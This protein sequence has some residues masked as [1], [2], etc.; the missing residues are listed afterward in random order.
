MVQIVPQLIDLYKQGKFPVEK[1][2]K[3]YPPDAIEQAL[4]DLHSGNVRL[5]HSK[6]NIFMET[7]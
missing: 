1:L 3:I 6:A 7:F 5:P 4:A 2:A